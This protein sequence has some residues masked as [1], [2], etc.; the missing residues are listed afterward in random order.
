MIVRVGELEIHQD[1]DAMEDEAADLDATKEEHVAV[2]DEETTK[3]SSP[4]EEL[5]DSLTHSIVKVISLCI[6]S[7][8]VVMR[9]YLLSSLAAVEGTHRHSP[10][11]WRSCET[12]EPGSR[13]VS[14]EPSQKI[15]S[16]GSIVLPGT[17]C[18][19]DDIF[20]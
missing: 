9:C 3:N 16:G 12:L 19:I 4:L 20:N 17:N 7:C 10:T 14:T 5:F 13:Y 8:L 6:K 18:F 11:R 2:D 1:D 15:C